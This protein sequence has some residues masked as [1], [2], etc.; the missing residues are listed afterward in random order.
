M[1]YRTALL[2]IGL[3]ATVAAPAQACF[4]GVEHAPSY[5]IVPADA[6][7]LWPTGPRAVTTGLSELGILEG[8]NIHL[9]CYLETVDAELDEA[10]EEADPEDGGNLLGLQPFSGAGGRTGGTRR[11]GGR[12]T[13]PSMLTFLGPVS[14]GGLG[15]FF[16]SSGGGEDNSDTLAFVPGTDGEEGG[17]NGGD[18]A[19]DPNGEDPNG[20]PPGGPDNPPGGPGIDD[21]PGGPGTEDVVTVVPEPG[22]GY[23]LSMFLL[24]TAAL[25]RRRRRRARYHRDAF[26]RQV[27]TSTG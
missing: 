19:F 2:C 12:G 17:E 1:K 11:T 15:G 13:P 20:L 25:S 22:T 4:V 6:A 10:D 16:G 24:T 26:S 3:I 23:L 14:G 21:L 27:Q 9:R 8:D 18:P 7:T 5:E